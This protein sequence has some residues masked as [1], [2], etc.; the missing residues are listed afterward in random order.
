M[1]IIFDASFILWC[2]SFFTAL[3][4]LIKSLAIKEKVNFK[5]F[6][7]LAVSHVSLLLLLIINIPSSDKDVGNSPM[8]IE[9]TKVKTVENPVEETIEEI[10]DEPVEEESI[11]IWYSS[12]SIDL[13]NYDAVKASSFV[14]SLQDT[15]LGDSGYFRINDSETAVTYTPK[16]TMFTYSLLDYADSID[17]ENYM[18]LLSRYEE[19]SKIIYNQ[20]GLGYALMD[21]LNPD[22]TLALFFNGSTIVDFINNYGVA[23]GYWKARF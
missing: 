5:F 1:G 19:L 12:L 9:K 13:D 6:K 7:L 11:D 2:L 8:E 3:Y 16:T 14:S 15:E 4:S 23:S 18:L 17:L 20:T 21:P 10:V 22:N